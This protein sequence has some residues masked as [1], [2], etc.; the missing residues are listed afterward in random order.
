MNATNINELNY[1]FNEL[2]DLAYYRSLVN[3]LIYRVYKKRWK[4]IPE[5][6]VDNNSYSQ[7][8]VRMGELS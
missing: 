5:N 7:I 8:W 6:R 3:R 2:L 1:L 4:S